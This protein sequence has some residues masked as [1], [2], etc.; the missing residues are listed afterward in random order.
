M[1]AAN[2]FL[3]SSGL[4]QAS[5][6]AGSVPRL[7]PPPSPGGQQGESSSG[8]RLEGL[9]ADVGVFSLTKRAFRMDHLDSYSVEVNGALVTL[10]TVVVEQPLLPGGSTDRSPDP[11]RGVSPKAVKNLPA[12]VGLF[13]FSEEHLRLPHLDS[14]WVTVSPASNSGQTCGS[15]GNS[16]T[17][18][19]AGDL[20]CPTTPSKGQSRLSFCPTPAFGRLICLMTRRLPPRISVE[21]FCRNLRSFPDGNSP[22]N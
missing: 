22:F 11:T 12:D 6:A 13:S 3:T 7:P 8:Q 1:A 16:G 5:S 4:I 15:S 20:A 2:S 19:S 17:A 10:H 21:G 14:R 9:P 18:S